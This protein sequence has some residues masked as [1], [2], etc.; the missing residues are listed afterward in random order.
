M[1]QASMKNG[2]G[3][4]PAIDLVHLSR[5]TLGDRT[6]ERE[7]LQLFARQAATLLGEMR[8]AAPTAAA[9][10]AHRLKG[11]AQGTGAWRVAAAAGAVEQA[12]GRPALAHAMTT[13]ASCVHE[14]QALIADLLRPHE[15]S[16]P[17]KATL[18]GITPSESV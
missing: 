13:L 8:G 14:A 7:V 16:R 1:T 4:E 10:L 9:A 5:M 6:L 17:V 3:S 11:S 12:A 2:A 18:S 15:A